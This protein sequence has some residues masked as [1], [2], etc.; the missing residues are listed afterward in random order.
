[1]TFAA[2]SGRGS[3]AE[4]Y[5]AGLL[6]ALGE[7]AVVRDGSD[8]VAD[9]ASSGAMALTGEADGPPLAAPGPVV[10]LRGALLALQALAPAVELPGTSVLG[11]RAALAGLGR[12]GSTSAGGMTRLLNARDGLVA[13]AL[14]RDEDRQ[15]VPALVEATV[16]DPWDAV[17]AWV[18]ESTVATVRSRCSLVGLPCGIRGEAGASEGPW[19][20]LVERGS[21]SRVRK[22]PV[23]VDLSAL[24]AGPLCASIL[25]R[26]GCDVVK[27]EDPGRP[28]GARKGPPAFYELLHRG[29]RTEPIDLRSISGRTRLRQLVLS[30]DVVLEASRPRALEQLGLDAERIVKAV[31]TNLTWVSI[32][33][34]GRDQPHR[35][36]YGDDAAV[37]GGLVASSARGSVFVADAVADPLTGVHAALVAWSG[38]R[39]GG[40]RLVDL[41]LSRVAASA[42]ASYRGGQ[43]VAVR[44]SEAWWIDTEVGRVRVAE[45]VARKSDLTPDP[46]SRA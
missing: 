10:A 38:I 29:A 44:N 3:P 27:V 31:G 20:V 8:P 30:A 15:L 4:L 7:R 22:R 14:V 37:A 19:R 24:W 2:A 23:V 6:T 43:P 46:V 45:P 11:E 26:L 18:A 41:A 28:D 16:N 36:G 25:T 1:M 32:T 34:H 12:H 9:W 13:I 35:V 5:A 39:S 33:G 40:S 17:S 42:A 21:R